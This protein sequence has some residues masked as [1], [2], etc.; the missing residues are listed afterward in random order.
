MCMA[1]GGDTC[2]VWETR[3]RVARKT[4]KCAE[5]GRVIAK[6]ESHRFY[7]GLIY[8]SW[9]D[10]RQCAHCMVMADWLSRECGGFLTEGVL[11]DFEEHA[12]EYHR[13]DL[14]RL[15]WGGRHQWRRNGALLPI[16]TLPLTS[17]QLART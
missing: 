17:E 8:G 15:T 16:P 6:G 2:D 13:F 4:H 10:G 11:E 7:K 5:C 3:T 12:R 14:W 9:F 1:D